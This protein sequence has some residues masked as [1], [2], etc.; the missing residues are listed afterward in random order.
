MSV[1]DE[2]MNDEWGERGSDPCPP[3][4]DGPRGHAGDMWQLWDTWGA[5]PGS[6]LVI[7]VNCTRTTP[8]GE[9]L[10]GGKFG[11]MGK[12]CALQAAR[13]WPALAN[14]WSSRVAG[15]VSEG[16][17]CSPLDPDPFEPA[18]DRRVGVLVTKGN[19][20]DASCPALVAR[21][22]EQLADWAHD[23]S[24][25]GRDRFVMPLPG[26]G[27]GGLAPEVSKVLCRQYLDSRFV[28]CTGE[29]FRPGV[30]P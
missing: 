26:S 19:W 4:G 24:K 27:C 10:R 2:L 9:P 20:W 15:G 3:A 16:W 12:G 22:L 6:V 7:T 23:A 8:G 18:M 17:H 25:A 21:G 29:K 1:L 11:V 30:R 5:H 14:W 28:V 13:R